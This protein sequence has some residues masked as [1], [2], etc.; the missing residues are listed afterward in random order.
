MAIETS[1]NYHNYLR[2]RG[3]HKKLSALRVEVKHIKLGW[4]FGVR[5]KLKAGLDGTCAT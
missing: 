2:E 3:Y 1:V 5:E 4:N